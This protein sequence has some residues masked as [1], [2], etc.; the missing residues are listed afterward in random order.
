MLSLAKKISNRIVK[1][2]VLVHAKIT[3]VNLN[4]EEISIEHKNIYLGGT[5]KH[6][7]NKLL[8]EG[9]ISDAQYNKF[10]LAAHCYFKS[11]LA[12]ILGKFPLK[13][14]LIENAVW[15]N[16]PQ[17][18]EAEWKNVEYFY[19][20]FEAAFH[21]IP[22]DALYEEFCDYRSLSDGDIGGDALASSKSG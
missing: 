19:D 8:N 16:V 2:Q 1:P 21:E 7:L 3:D 10:F 15:I 5:T 17:R 9:H 20:R 14:E 22:V 18:I 12:Y 11:S 13:E 6:T 4:E